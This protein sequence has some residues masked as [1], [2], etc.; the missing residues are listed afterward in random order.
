MDLQKTIKEVTKYMQDTLLTKEFF[1]LVQKWAQFESAPVDY[2][3]SDVIAYDLGIWKQGKKSF[4]V[5]QISDMC[6]DIVNTEYVIICEKR[7]SQPVVQQ[8]EIY[9]Y[10]VAIGFDPEQEEVGYEDN[11]LMQGKPTLERLCEAFESNKIGYNYRSLITW[12]DGYT[13]QPFNKSDRFQDYNGLMSC[14]NDLEGEFGDEIKEPKIWNIPR[15]NKEVTAKIKELADFFD[16]FMD[17]K[18]K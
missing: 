9:I 10:A 8:L 11:L 14:L 17:V 15:S 1:N 6:G 12:E 2:G 18:E 3:D 4:N 16:Q 13:L 5:T 7:D